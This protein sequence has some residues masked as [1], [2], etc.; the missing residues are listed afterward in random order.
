[1]FSL[2]KKIVVVCGG[3]GLIG[4]EVSKA[5]VRQGAFTII[6]DINAAK[7]KSFLNELDAENAAYMD[8]NITEESSVLEFI[9]TVEKDYGQIWAWINLAYPRTEDWG[10]R[11]EDIKIDSF[12]KNIDLQLNSQF[13]CC[14]AILETMKNRKKGVVINFSSIYGVQS[15]NFNIYEGTEITTP[16]A[17]SA[18]KSGI[19]NFT[20]Y[21]AAYYGKYN[22]RVNCIAPG[23]VF[24]N[25]NP[26]F[27]NNYS[28]L[29]PLNRMG[30]A[31]E[32]APGVIFLISE[33]ASY[34]TG[35]TLVVDGGFTIW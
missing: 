29:T 25:Q 23:G 34:I 2:K 1:M 20:R 33:E 15:P 31:D 13:I 9:N 26:I 22:L 14:K 17:Y 8:I 4:K 24:D 21:L 6:A 12:R 27:V 7:G 3:L 16:A 10:S 5:A 11:I 30:N 19:I 32:I 28:K 18:I 35:Q